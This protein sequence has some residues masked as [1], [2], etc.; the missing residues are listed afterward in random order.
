MFPGIA[1]ALT[2]GSDHLPVILDLMEPAPGA[3][4]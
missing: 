3:G 2:C 1:D 4:N